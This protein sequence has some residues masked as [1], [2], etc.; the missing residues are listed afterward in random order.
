[1]TGAKPRKPAQRRQLHQNL[2]PREK[3]LRTTPFLERD[4]EHWGNPP[5][6]QTAIRELERL[7]CSGS[8]F[9]A[10]AWTAFWWLEEYPGLA[11]HLET[12]HRRLLSNDRV[13]LLDLRP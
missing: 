10:F 11:H 5:D 7:R 8:G 13:I 3:R 12:R 2:K 6:D 4:G 9:I 1:M